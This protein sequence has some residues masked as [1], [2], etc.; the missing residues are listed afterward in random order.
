MSTI[1]EN[2]VETTS[3]DDHRS[4]LRARYERVKERVAQAAQRSGRRAEDIVLV[5]VTKYAAIDDVR[6]LLKLGQ[7]DFG[8]NRVQNLV[9]RTAQIEEY[10]HRHH[11]LARG[12]ET[13]V[14]KAARWHMIGHLQRN[15]VRKVLPLVR[16]LHSVDSLRLAE[17]IQTCA[18]R[19]DEPVEILV[20]VNAANE[21]QKSGVAP[22]AARHLIDQL[23]TM[24][25]LR[26]RGL[27]CMAP[28][29]EDPEESRQYFQL[30][31]ELF[32]DIRRS[33][34]AG[35]RFDIL[36]MGMTN[37]FEVAIECGANIV[38]V[39]SAIF[40]E[41]AMMNDDDEALAEESEDDA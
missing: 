27:M 29:V 10:I 33:G 6:E 25:N 8:E 39:G 9:Q 30:V 22:A 17:E 38:R 5:A 11:D 15:K 14:P 2:H 41:R 16:L 19:Y 20:Q 31:Q 4:E 37:D 32:A 21:K 35:E 34:A 23:N 40:G 7:M 3:S 1:P 26:V 13:A 18:A 36:S 12:R 28:H 24:L